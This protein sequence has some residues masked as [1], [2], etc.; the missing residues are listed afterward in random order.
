M[1]PQRFDFKAGDRIDRFTVLRTLG[2]GTYG[3]VY[4]VRDGSGTEYA[5][6]VLKL[7]GI[8]ETE[9]RKMISL[10]FD[11]EFKTGQLTSDYI[12]HSLEKGKVKGNPYILMEFMPNDSLDVRIPSLKTEKAIEMGIVILKGLRDLHDNDIIHRDIKPENVLLDLS[13]QPRLTD[14]GIAGFLNARVTVKNFAN[15]VKDIFGTYAYIAPEQL[16]DY[17]KFKT[18]GPKT[19]LFSFGVLFYEMLTNGHFPFGPLENDRDLATYIRRAAKGEIT[20][21]ASHGV[22]VAPGVERALLGCLSAKFEERLPYVNNALELMG[23]GKNITWASFPPSP[24]S[25]GSNYGQHALLEVTTG[26]DV[27]RR[28]DLDKYTYPDQPSAVRIGYLD[29]KR[30]GRN[31]VELIERATEYISNYHATIEHHPSLKKWIIRDGQYRNKNGQQEWHFSTNGV[32]L[33]HQAVARNEISYLELTNNCIIQ[34]GDVTLRF[35][36]TD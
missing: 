3:I 21:L 30:P 2:E 20:P 34:L 19:D 33:N 1:H 16:K 25:S 26:E 31:H 6:K 5:L 7:H 13:G 32:F 29:E 11:G 36:F 28:Y 27:G 14:F 10:R 9:T 17:K 18:T 35:R 22:K 4:H 12:V 8:I 23:S 15:R 24:P